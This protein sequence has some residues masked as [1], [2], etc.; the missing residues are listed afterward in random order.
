MPQKETAEMAA[1]YQYMDDW[2]NGFLAETQREFPGISLEVRLDAD[3]VMRD[4]KQEL[5]SHADTY[6]CKNAD[7]TAA[8]YGIPMGFEN[9]GERV[10]A[11]NAVTKTQQILKDLSEHN[12]SKPVYLEQFIFLDNTPQFSLNARLRE[13]EVTPYLEKVVPTLQKYSRGYGLWA[14]RDY[15]NNVLYNA[16][17]SLGSAGWETSGD[18]SFTQLH[19]MSVCNMKPGSVLKQQLNRLRRL[20]DFA[21]SR[22]IAFDVIFL[23]APAV[24][25]VRLG[26]FEEDLTVTQTGHVEIP[27]S[28][29]EQREQWEFAI[30][31]RSGEVVLDHMRVYSYV[32]TG[33]LYHLDGS[34]YEYLAGIRRL[35]AALRR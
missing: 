4:G 6:S 30:E 20:P 5:Y 10:T 28:S 11:D 15:E 2:L 22:K 33:G 8:M 35:N 17:F 9:H 13:D 3:P 21:T 25:R 16:D 14:Y 34:P 27:I 7:Y 24:L 23:D 19:G 32:T 12:G 18:V 26:G 29:P 31:S 1:M